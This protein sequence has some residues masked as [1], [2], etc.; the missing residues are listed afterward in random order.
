MHEQQGVRPA[1]VVGI[2]PGETR[3]LLVVIA[4]LTTRIGQWAQQN[5]VIYPQLP[6]GTGGLTQNSVVLLDQIRAIDAQRIIKY[7]GSLAP[8]QYAPIAAGINQ[9]L[10]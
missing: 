10:N 5:P 1:V 4:P 9:L 2:P 3:Y 8:K 7:I 6:A